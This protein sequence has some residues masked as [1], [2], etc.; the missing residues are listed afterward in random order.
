MRII[1]II[2][3]RMAASRFPGKPMF[4]ILGRPMVE[5]VFR[6][7]EL[8]QGWDELAIATCDE[9]ISNFAK[10]K[11]FPVFMTGSH[12]IRAL[13][14]VAEAG[15]LF[16]QKLVDDDIVVCVQGDEPMLS[17]DM[18]EVVI[19]PLKMNKLIPATV[20][21]MHIVEEEIW[22]NPDTVKII[23][24]EKGEV[25][26]TSRMALPYCK[27]KFSPELGARRIYGIFAF[28]WKYLQEF[29]KHPETRLEKLEA[30]DSNRILDMNFTQYIA[31]YPYVKSYSVD[32]PSDITLVENH[33]KHDKYF[34]MY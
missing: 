19:A 22:K 34:Q 24:N 27:G 33:M 1:G 2:P 26:Y 32:S 23:H 25:L 6:R 9:E 11:N 4:P 7:A 10:S 14:R 12:H 20:L 17:P 30:C 8:Y 16:T 31:P 13:D 21:A 15:T 3:A 5:H 28:R 29:T 18:L